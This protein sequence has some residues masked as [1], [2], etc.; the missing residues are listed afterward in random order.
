VTSSVAL[1]AAAA[2]GPLKPTVIARRDLRPDDTSDD[3]ERW[4]A[5][6]G[7]G[8]RCPSFRG[9]DDAPKMATLSGSSSRAR[10]SFPLAHGVTLGCTGSRIWSEQKQNRDVIAVGQIGRSA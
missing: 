7:E 3:P 10:P 6:H 1:S 5:V 4:L 9:S 8:Y 2:G